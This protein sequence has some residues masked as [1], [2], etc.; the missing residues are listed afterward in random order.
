MAMVKTRR[1]EQWL[2]L[3]D[4]DW[5]TYERLLRAFGERRSIRITYDRGALEIVNISYQHEEPSEFL[6]RLIY[7]LTEELGLPVISG[8]STTLKRQKKQRGLEPDKC[9][10]I[11]H[12]PDMFGKKSLDLRIDPPPDLAIETDVTHSSINRMGIYAA[13]GISEVW[14]CE[15]PKLTFHVL[16]A[17]GKYG[18]DG[19]SAIFAGLTAAALLPFLAMWGQMDENALVR[20]FREWVR[21]QMAAGALKR[22]EQVATKQ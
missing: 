1:R 14:R 10:W 20:K 13:L 2:R 8:G 21:E 22:P 18:P 3:D 6:G 9:Y 16:G 5:K 17:D 19:P 11:T 15:E 12:A 4:A 7:V